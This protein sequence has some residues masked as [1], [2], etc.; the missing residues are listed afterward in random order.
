MAKKSKVPYSYK[1]RTLKKM[2]CSRC[3]NVEKVAFDT[4]SVVCWH[5]VVT[6]K[7]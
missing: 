4:T 5:C 3:E 6:R 7:R 2:K 1:D